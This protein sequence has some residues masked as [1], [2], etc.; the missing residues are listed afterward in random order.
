M[1]TR[2]YYHP[3]LAS[4]LLLFGLYVAACDA[5]KIYDLFTHSSYGDFIFPSYR[6]KMASKLL[7]KAYRPCISWLFPFSGTLSLTYFTLSNF[8]AF[9]C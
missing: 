2:E 5:S 4:T 3:D 7:H 6:L 8:L 1:S 9:S